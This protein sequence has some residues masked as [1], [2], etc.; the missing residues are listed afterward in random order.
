MEE[1][2]KNLLK[3]DFTQ[4]MY[5]LRHYDSVNWDITKFTFTEMII[6]IGACWSIYTMCLPSSR[7][8]LQLN[9][10]EARLFII[11]ILAAS[12]AFGIWAL[13]TIAKNRG[14]FALTSRHINEYRNLAIQNNDIGFSNKAKYWSNESFPSDF[15]WS[16]TQ[17]FSFYLILFMTSVI[18]GALVFFG[19][20]YF[21]NAYI[22]VSVIISLLFCIV[23]LVVTHRIMNK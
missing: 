21:E 9:E 13:L 3:E 7:T 5:M 23:V 8:T 18:L 16:S 2:S 1:F 20:Q 11:T 6:A 15:D 14:Y 10:S 12:I 17:M 4:C 22:F 19:M